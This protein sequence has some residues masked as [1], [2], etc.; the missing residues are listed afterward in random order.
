M[1]RALAAL[2]CAVLLTG[3]PR[4]A[5]YVVLPSATGKA[6]GGITVDDGRTVTVLDHPYAAAESRGGGSAPIAEPTGDVS[7]IFRAAELARPILPHH[8]RLYFIFDS[9]RL[10]PESEAQYRAVFGDIRERRAYEVEVVGH[11]DTVGSQGY[12]QRLSLA[13][14]AAVRAAL[15]R[16]GVAADAIAIAGRG[17]LDLLVP[18]GDHVAE[19]RNRR[20]EIWVR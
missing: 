18:T 2:A 10:T 20:V 14:A 11:T 7:V 1:R 3:C 19:P 5:L 8:F 16:D 13:R 9:D 17:K 15:A 6:V 4:Q 12:N